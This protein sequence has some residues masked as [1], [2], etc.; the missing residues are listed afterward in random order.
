MTVLCLFYLNNQHAIIESWWRH[1]METFSVLL[2]L[3]AGNSPVTS[4]FPS[5]RPVAQSSDVF[6]DL[7]VNKQ[8]SKQSW[9]WWFETPSR[10]LWRHCNVHAGCR[11][12]TETTLRYRCHQNQVITVKPGDQTKLATFIFSCN[13]FCLSPEWFRFCQGTWQV[14]QTNDRH[15]VHTYIPASRWGHTQELWGEVQV[16]Q[17]LNTLRPRQDGH[18]FAD[19]I[20]KLFSWMQK[21]ELWLIF[22]EVCS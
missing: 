11:F 14:I 5:Q 21:N 12:D 19:D 2:A 16:L 15:V 20:F 7:S 18:L 22:T 10:S 8:L 1:Q 9:D 3:C 13:M 6:F 17:V 4:E